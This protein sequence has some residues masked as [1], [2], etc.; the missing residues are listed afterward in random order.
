MANVFRKWY[1]QRFHDEEAMLL[2][3]IL[4]T[5]V[6]LIL[7]FGEILTPVIAALVLAFLCQGMVN[8]LM[9]YKVPHF[10]AVVVSFIF[11]LVLEFA[12]V[13][14]LSTLVLGQLDNFINELPKLIVLLQE[15]LNELP[16]RYPAALSEEQVAEWSAAMN[17]Q[18][19]D[20]GQWVVTFSQSK[21]PNLLSFLVYLILVPV[22][23]FF[24]LKDKDKILGWF[25]G[26][27]P[28]QRPLLKQVWNDMNG[29]MANYV[30]GKFIEMFIVGAITYIVFMFFDLRYAALLAISVGLSVIVPYVGA[31]LVTIPVLMVGYLQ[32]GLGPEFVKLFIAYLVV[33]LLDGNVLVPWLF[34]EAVNLHPVAILLAIMFFGGIW[35]LWGVFFAIP[36]A[37]LINAV[38][39]AWPTL[40]SEFSAT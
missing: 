38:L 16:E 39:T 21:I 35:G 20:F 2:L 15:R 22:L 17:A 29:Q 28:Q 3:L 34:S 25:G 6:G 33:Q 26:L 30:R 9:R 32:W 4:C 11:L 40:Q 37:T 36:L 27:L 31:F 1:E 13:S 7:F 23:V 24:F 18:I 8:Y 19:A 12:S 14:V 10:F 5:G